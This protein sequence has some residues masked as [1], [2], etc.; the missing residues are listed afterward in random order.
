MKVKAH[1]ST[2]LA[3]MAFLGFL[4][5]AEAEVAE[6]EPPTEPLQIAP[7]LHK[8][9]T[10][11]GTVLNGASMSAAGD[12][13]APP[14]AGWNYVHATN[15]QGYWDGTT[16]WLYVFPQ[17]GGFWYTA[18]PYLQTT[19]APACQ[20]GNWIAFYVYNTSGNLWNYVY[21]YTYK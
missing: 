16:T 4:G 12:A 19:I 9:V 10:K 1:L 6:S 7:E 13:V 21:T 2:V 3:M 15:C 5:V 20:T 8:A 14:V 11:G 17:E 18:N